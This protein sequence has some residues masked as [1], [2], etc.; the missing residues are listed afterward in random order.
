MIS[1]TLSEKSKLKTLCPDTL[2][3]STKVRGVFVDL[4][5]RLLLEGFGYIEKPK[6]SA[7]LTPKFELLT[8]KKPRSSS[9]SII[10]PLA[11]NGYTFQAPLLVLTELL[12]G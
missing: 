9:L 7:S 5:V 6:S 3:I 1:E 2:Y 12:S 10:F 4:I 8:R 11:K